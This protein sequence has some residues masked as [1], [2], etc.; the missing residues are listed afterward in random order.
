M[1]GFVG[2]VI[3][4]LLTGGIELLMRTRD[5]AAQVRAASRLGYEYF[6]HR[7]WR[8]GYAASHGSWHLLQPEPEEP[9]WWSEYKPLFARLVSSTEWTALEKGVFEAMIIGG[10]VHVPLE[11]YEK[12]REHLAWRSF[13]YVR[14][15]RRVLG[16]RA[17]LDMGRDEGRATEAGFGPPEG[18]D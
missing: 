15:A 14:D 18:Q 10:Q 6:D 9:G 11:A 7:E 5:E 13:A 2:V 12:N 3:G 16:K 8:I 17:G 1:V 4:A